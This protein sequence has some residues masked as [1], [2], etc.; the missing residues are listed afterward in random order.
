MLNIGGVINF[1]LN[2]SCKYSWDWFCVDVPT[3]EVATIY[4]TGLGVVS[5]TWTVYMNRS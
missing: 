4:V 1:E 5:G 3:S 2:S